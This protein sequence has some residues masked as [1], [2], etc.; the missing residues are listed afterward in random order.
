M[1]FMTDLTAPITFYLILFW[2]TIRKY[3]TF[4]LHAMREGLNRIC[5]NAKWG[6][7]VFFSKRI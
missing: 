7:E 3:D 6:M 4:L 5:Q 2:L 1:Y